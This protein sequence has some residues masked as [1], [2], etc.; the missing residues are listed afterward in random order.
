M[1]G[2]RDESV[3]GSVERDRWLRRWERDGFTISAAHLSGGYR[4]MCGH[5]CTL[6]PRSGTT[7]T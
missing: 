5:R 6:L 1:L 3:D 7:I 4:C 2:S